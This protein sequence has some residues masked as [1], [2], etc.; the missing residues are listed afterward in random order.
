MP[1]ACPS[2]SSSRRIRYEPAVPVLR[3]ATQVRGAVYHHTGTFIRIQKRWRTALPAASQD[4]DLLMPDGVTVR[5]HYTAT[6]AFPYIA[7]PQLVGWIKKWFPYGTGREVVIVGQRSGPLLVQFGAPAGGALPRTPRRQVRRQLRRLGRNR[8]RES[9]ERWERDPGLRRAVLA[10]WAA[11]CQVVGC[12]AARAAGSLSDRVVDVHHL[13]SVSK[14]G[15]D[16]GL[17]IVILCVLHHVLMHRAPT[18]EIVTSDALRVIAQ[19]DGLTLHIKRDAFAL[20]RAL[21]QP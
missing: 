21:Q 13:R 5:G 20:M 17:N 18:V 1:S 9:F 16:S 19:V 14:G 3:G 15:G 12:R 8:K 11:R 6:A 10:V 4:V 7:G 2:K